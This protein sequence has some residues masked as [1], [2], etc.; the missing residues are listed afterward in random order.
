MSAGLL[1]IQR[2]REIEDEVAREAGLSSLPQGGGAPLER[3][4][5]PPSDDDDKKTASFVEDYAAAAKKVMILAGVGLVVR[6]AFLTLETAAARSRAPP[7]LTQT[8]TPTTLHLRDS[9]P[10]RSRSSPLPASGSPPPLRLGSPSAAPP[11][12]AAGQSWVAAPLL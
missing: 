10:P 11:L 5:E 9:S 4:A 1:S 7:G 3:A 8:Q 6:L 2:R 12:V